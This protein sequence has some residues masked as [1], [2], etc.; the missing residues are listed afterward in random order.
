MLRSAIALACLVTLSGCNDGIG[1]SRGGTG[2]ATGAPCPTILQEVAVEVFQP[3][4]LTSGC[5]GSEDRAGGLDLETSALELQ[6]YGR[7]A[8]LCG[9]ETRVVPGDSSAS[10][11]IA[12]LRGTSDCGAQMPIGVELAT[13]T[14]DCMAA[15]IDQLDASNACETCGG[16]GASTCRPTRSI[17]VRVGKPAA[18]PRFALTVAVHAPATSRLATWVVSISTATRRTAD[19]VERGAATCSVSKA[20]VLRTAGRSPNVEARASIC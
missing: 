2:G 6:L 12:K 17:V 4:C 7:E 16:T 14:I 11:L 9:G 19:H 18:V 8:A 5:H 15:W 10:H 20:D 3:S 13:E 1:T